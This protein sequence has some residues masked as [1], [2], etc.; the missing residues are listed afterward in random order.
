LGLDSVVPAEPFLIG[1]ALDLGVNRISLPLVGRPRA[2]S[3]TE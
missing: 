1:L 3:G 2:I